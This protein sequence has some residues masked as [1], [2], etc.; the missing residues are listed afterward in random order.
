MMALVALL[1]DPNWN[2]LALLPFLMVV[3]GVNGGEDKVQIRTTR[4]MEAGIIAIMTAIVTA[5]ATSFVLMKAMDI[6][7]NF[8]QKSIT[9]VEKKVDHLEEK[10]DKIIWERGEK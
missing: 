3:K 4:I 6:E 9:N 7:L 5:S 2:W 10:M 8:V 1:K